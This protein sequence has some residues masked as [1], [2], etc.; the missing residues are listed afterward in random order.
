M[1]L[2]SNE[3]DF[4]K[5]GG[6]PAPLLYNPII[7]IILIHLGPSRSEQ[8]DSI[9]VYAC[10]SKILKWL[11]M[12]QLPHCVYISHPWRTSSRQVGF[13][14]RVK[15]LRAG[16]GGKKRWKVL[17]REEGQHAVFFLK[18]EQPTFLLSTGPHPTCS[19]APSGLGW[20]KWG[21]RRG[22]WEGSTRA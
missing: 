13:P 2:L 12:G 9:S 19:Q 21:T 4:T 18:Q 11:V 20:Q 14:P 16:A 15:P 22:Y 7:L 5:H 6:N 1:G 3:L 17:N 8:I 10:I